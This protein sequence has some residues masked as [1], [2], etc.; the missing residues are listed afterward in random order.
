M[1]AK[2][3]I[4]TGGATR[5]G[6]AIA[7]KLA[8]P[9]KEIVI[10]FNRSK[11]KAEELK[12][13]LSLLGAKIYLI[14]AD[15]SKDKDLKKIIKYLNKYDLVYTVRNKYGRVSEFI[16]SYL[17]K[18]IYNICDPLSGLKGYRRNVLKKYNFN[19]NLNLF[20]SEVLISSINQNYR[21]KYFNIKIQSRKD[22]PRIGN[23]ITANLKI[24]IS[25]ISLVLYHFTKKN[26]L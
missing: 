24:L 16:F 8:G 9:N 10:H 19:M 22:H 18:K 17:A 21:I 7:E 1:E 4:I 11:S 12:K 2:K 6:A 20:G 26:Y 25:C 14:R 13:K 15:L 23:I 3:I 5:I